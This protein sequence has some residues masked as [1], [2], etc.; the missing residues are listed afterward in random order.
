MTPEMLEEK[1]LRV[2]EPTLGRSQARA[3]WG[4]LNGIDQFEDVREL[5]SVLRPA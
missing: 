5:V 3:A 4:R 1:F 2:S